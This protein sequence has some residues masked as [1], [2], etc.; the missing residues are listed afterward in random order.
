[1]SGRL[2]KLARRYYS[3]ATRLRPRVLRLV[4]MDINSVAR[5][6]DVGLGLAG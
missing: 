6:V 4:G 2:L 5:V 1:M 3:D